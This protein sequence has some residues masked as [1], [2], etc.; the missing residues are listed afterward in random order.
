MGRR[1]AMVWKG[2]Y[3]SAVGI[4]VGVGHVGRHV[5]VVLVIVRARPAPLLVHVGVVCV[6]WRHRV[7]MVGGVVCSGCLTR[8]WGA[9]G[10]RHAQL[11]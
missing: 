9:V 10:R 7:K 4:G 2:W 3:L 6:G 11:V 8:A 1:D 5:A